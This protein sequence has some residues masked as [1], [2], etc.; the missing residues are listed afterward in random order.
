MGRIVI[1]DRGET[2]Q[3]MREATGAVRIQT[4]VL[5]DRV[6]KVANATVSD[7]T[8][9]RRA[10]VALVCKLG[11]ALRVG[12]GIGVG[13]PRGYWQ[14]WFREGNSFYEI[15]RRGEIAINRMNIVA[16][17]VTE[18]VAARKVHGLDTPWPKFVPPV[19]F[20]QSDSDK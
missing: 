4:G 6:A 19:P 20:D 5:A 15:G 7:L 13:V 16:L 3:V 12:V 14:E 11:D 8:L 10:A 2:V 18:L 1:N 9:D 17:S